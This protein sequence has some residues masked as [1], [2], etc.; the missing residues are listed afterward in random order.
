[1]M[2]DTYRSMNEHITP[3]PEL[4]RAV[5]EKAAPRRALRLRPAVALV[6]VL[7]LILSAPQALA[8]PDIY[9]LLHGVSPE[10]AARFAP[11]QESCEAN[12]IRMEVVAASVHGKS[13]EIYFT[14]E[15]LESS[16][17]AAQSY[18]ET[19]DI[20]GLANYGCSLKNVGFDEETGRVTLLL[21]YETIGEDFR[22]TLWSSKV[23]LY[24]DRITTFAGTT[25]HLLP[26]TLTDGG[27]FTLSPRR[28]DAGGNLT[29]DGSAEF[30]LCG[31]D[32]YYQDKTEIE[33]LRPQNAGE[34]ITDG[35]RL[36]GLAYVGGEL[37]IQTMDASALSYSLYL[38]DESGSTLSPE[39]FLTFAP[40]QAEGIQYQ[41]DVFLLGPQALENCT[42]M[43]RVDRYETIEGPWRITFDLDD[44]L[45]TYH[46]PNDD[47]EN[48]THP[49][50]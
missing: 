40:E 1:M 12:G 34:A 44:A 26:I 11:V 7:A 10:T 19:S 28:V 17:L 22:D 33:L 21:D 32:S 47:V 36:T 25:E 4:K 42:L 39:R 31:Y 38:V 16:R 2:E 50:E 37:H 30:D 18:P 5:L 45:S 15:D 41:E 6:L 13:A 27:T 49:T 43:V 23:T 48:V 8:N 9:Q 35:I 3:G 24:L 29:E 14:M 20:F 46:D